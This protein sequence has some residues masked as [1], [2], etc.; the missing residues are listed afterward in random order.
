MKRLLPFFVLLAIGLICVPSF[1]LAQENGEPK[2]PSVFKPLADAAQ[3]IE[4]ALA[5]SKKENRRVLN[6]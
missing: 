1:G 5:K 6:S 3:Q 2:S 4:S